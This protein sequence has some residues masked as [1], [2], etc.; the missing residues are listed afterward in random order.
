M[1]RGGGVTSVGSLRGKQRGFHIALQFRTVLRHLIGEF[2][3]TASLVHAFQGTG[4]HNRLAA[5][6]RVVP[7]AG[8]WRHSSE[9]GDIITFKCRVG[10]GSRRQRIRL[11][12]EKRV[13]HVH[14]RGVGLERGFFRRDV[15]DHIR[16]VFTDAF[17]IIAREGICND[18][19]SLFPFRASPPKRWRHR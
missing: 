15:I 11:P 4:D 3:A 14:T 13:F 1:T 17:G 9:G 7:K 19:H 2:R 6:L 18:S 12:L 8:S 10:R 5:N 16:Q